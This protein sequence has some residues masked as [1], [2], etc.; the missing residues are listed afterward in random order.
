MSEKKDFDTVEHSNYILT[1][2]LAAPEVYADGL[3]HVAIFGSMAKM[4]LHSVSWPKG[5]ENPELRRAVLNVTMP[6]ASAIELAHFVLKAAKNAEA[7]LLDGMDEDHATRVR[8]ILSEVSPGLPK[9]VRVD[10]S[11]KAAKKKQ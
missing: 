1:G 10:S 4:L 8:N 3:S 5:G 7:Q 11:P 9:D 2:R 6:A